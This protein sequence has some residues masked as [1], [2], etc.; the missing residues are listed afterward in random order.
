MSKLGVSSWELVVG[1][2]SRCG[3]VA[4][5][6]TWIVATIIIVL[7]LLF[8]IFG[9]SLLATTKKIEYRESLFLGNG[10]VGDDFLLKKNLFTYYSSEDVKD[11]VKILKDLNSR[12]ILGEFEIPFNETKDEIKLRMEGGV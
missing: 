4:D 7:I 8:F 9:A 6:V 1:S 11:R 2:K 12:A 3:Q 5:A 10:K